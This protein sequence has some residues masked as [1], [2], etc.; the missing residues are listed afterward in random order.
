MKTASVTMNAKSIKLWSSSNPWLYTVTA[1][2]YSGPL[3]SGTAADD[4]DTVHGFRSLY[5][6]AVSVLF[7]AS[8]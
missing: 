6:D 3:C 8:R 4:V 7:D 5:F 1:N 2:V